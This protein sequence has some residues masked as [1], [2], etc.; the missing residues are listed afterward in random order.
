VKGRAVPLRYSKHEEET[1]QYELFSGELRVGTIKSL[2]VGSRGA[3]IYVWT[4][5]GV[6]I[7]RGSF[8]SAAN[9]EEAKREM[10]MRWRQWLKD[11]GLSEERSP[12]HAEA[13]DHGLIF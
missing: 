10:V 11:A 1:G 6:R 13:A 8:G 3:A 9:L 5:S 4:I 12:P 2:R 7:G